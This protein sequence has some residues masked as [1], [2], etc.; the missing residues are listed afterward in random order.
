MCLIG[1]NIYGLVKN[2]NLGIFTF[3]GIIGLLGLHFLS[4]LDYLSIILTSL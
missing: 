2:I 3:L 4:L 1:Y